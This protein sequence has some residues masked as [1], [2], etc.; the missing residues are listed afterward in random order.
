MNINAPNVSLGHY[1]FHP[2]YRRTDLHPYQSLDSIDFCQWGLVPDRV[3]DILPGR[4]RDHRRDP[5][6]R[7]DIVDLFADHQYG[8]LIIT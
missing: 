1:G 8:D 5:A 4:Y 2:V 6:G 7:R 3:L